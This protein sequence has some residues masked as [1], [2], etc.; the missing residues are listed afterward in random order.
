MPTGTAQENEAAC[1]TEMDDVELSNPGRGEYNMHFAVFMIC[2]EAA[3][4]ESFIEEHAE[5]E[6]E[7]ATRAALIEAKQRA[8][9]PFRKLAH[10]VGGRAIKAVEAIG[11][12]YVELYNKSKSYPAIPWTFPF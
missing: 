5:L 10:K 1:I 11:E 7:L 2:R 3:E 4:L 8:V 6:A 9:E 12:P